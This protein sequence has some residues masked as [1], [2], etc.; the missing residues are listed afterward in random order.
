MSESIFFEK[1]LYLVATPIGNLGDLSP[2]AVAVL[3]NADVVA[4]EDTR[5]TGKLLSL[6]AIST[7][8]VNYHEH[9]ADKMRPVLTAR[10]KKG[11]TVALVSDAGTPLVS[12]PGHKLV[13]DCIKEGIYVTAVPGASALLTA[14]Q[15]SGLPTRR[16]LFQ[17]FL[18]PKSSA[19]KTTLAELKNVPSTLIFYEA[20]QRM[21]ETL[22]D[23]KE[24]LGDR[25]CSVSRELTKKFEQTVRGKISDILDLYAQNGVPKGEF[26]IVVAPPLEEKA[27]E[28]DVETALKQALE[29]MS[30]KD[31]AAFVAQAL[32]A[33]KKEVYT[34]ALKLKNG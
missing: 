24:V 34:L 19:R 22:T 3:K 27:G 13:A 5:I 16:F 18:P 30:V 31:A 7:P 10:L 2:R 21:I 6:N 29:T 15:L 14:L 9:N 20:P 33:N 26:V 17:G 32:N 11:E 1:G 4:C 8:M 12:D 28:Q 25:D 23:M